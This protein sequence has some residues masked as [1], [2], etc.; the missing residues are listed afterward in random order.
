MAPMSVAAIA[1]L[2]L[3]VKTCH[4]DHLP[5]KEDD[6]HFGFCVQGMQIYCYHLI[7]FYFTVYK[8]LRNRVNRVRKSLQKQF[9]SDKIHKLT[10]ENPAAW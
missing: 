8:S 4:F 1:L 6:F 2:S 9:Y 10:T 5:L 3:F 7:Y